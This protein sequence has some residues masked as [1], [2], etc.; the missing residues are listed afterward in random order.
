MG[1]ALKPTIARCG[2]SGATICAAVEVVLGAEVLLGANVIIADTDFHAL[3][4]HG[5][6]F[7]DNPADIGS[8]PVGI[9]DN[10]FVGT[11]ACI[12]K[13]V[14]IGANSVIGAGAVV[15][16]DIPPNVVAGGNP[17]RVIK[18]IPGQLMRVLRPRV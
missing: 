7:N 16:G 5:R 12:L 15:V 9:G 4:P 13:G 8:A 2:I 11:G 18:A 6:R 10:V 1:S 3:R 17:A 14:T